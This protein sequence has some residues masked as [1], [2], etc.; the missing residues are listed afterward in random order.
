M[1]TAQK[2]VSL[3]EVCIKWTVQPNSLHIEEACV[4]LSTG[5]IV[6]IKSLLDFHSN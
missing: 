1:E 4:R 6:Y 2:Y 5:M 3:L